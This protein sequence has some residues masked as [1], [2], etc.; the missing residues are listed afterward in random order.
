MRERERKRERERGRE[1]SRLHAGSLTWDSIL[2]LL[3][4]AVGQR[5]H[6]TTEP[7]RLP[8]KGF[9]YAKEDL[10][11]TGGLA[12]VKLDCFSL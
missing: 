10:Q 12:I 2:G 3:D 8:S 5:Q 11:D 9:S 4:Q 7:P 1:R 6:Q